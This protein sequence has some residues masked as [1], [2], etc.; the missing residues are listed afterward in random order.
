MRVKDLMKSNVVTVKPDN[1]VKHAAQIMLTR[2]IAG[3]PVVD[4]HDVLVGIITEGDLLGRSE[5][6]AASHQ[7]GKEASRNG[8][9][10][11]SRTI[12]GKSP[13]S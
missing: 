6:G 11:S 1:S 8:R 5:I 13:M 3:L 10:L 9:P 12:A 2:G 7:S 4:D